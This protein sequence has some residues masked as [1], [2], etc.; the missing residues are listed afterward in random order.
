MGVGSWRRKE[1]MGRRTRKKQLG[2]TEYRTP[3]IGQE[4]T[5][6][7]LVNYIQSEHAG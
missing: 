6:H 3:S 4:D 2:C 7:E 5:D 1:G